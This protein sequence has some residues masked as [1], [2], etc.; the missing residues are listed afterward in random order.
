MELE[1]WRAEVGAEMMRPNPDY[2]PSSTA[3]PK[4]KKA[5]GSR[6][7]HYRVYSLPP[8]SFT[9]QRQRWTRQVEF[10]GREVVIA[11]YSEAEI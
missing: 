10:L 8:R 1:A 4:K 2:D 3:M 5:G 11:D 7:V 9:A 6:E